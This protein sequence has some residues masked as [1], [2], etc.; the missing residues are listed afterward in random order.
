VDLV[1]DQAQC[2]VNPDRRNRRLVMWRSSMERRITN[3]YG[4]IK[5]SRSLPEVTLING[6]PMMLAIKTVTVGE[7]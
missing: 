2:L 6:L 5:Y 3:G 4:F 1:I 7:I